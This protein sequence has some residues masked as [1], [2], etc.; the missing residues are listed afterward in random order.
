MGKYQKATSVVDRY[1]ARPKYL[2]KM[3]LA[4]FATSYTYQAKPPKTAVFDDDGVSQLKSVQT[5]F[6]CGIFL[7]RHI[8]LEEGLGYMR[9]RR[10]PA[11]MRFHTSKNKEG[12]EKYYSEMLLFSHWT[13]ETDE[14]PMK[15][16]ECM[17]EY[18][19]RLDDLVVRA[20]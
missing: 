11:V 3:S 9:L 17:K 16:Y 8:S 13:N 15:E 19:K 4:Q 1:G 6:S 5:I 2:K 20:G 12:H 14:L 10:H 7:P 18:K